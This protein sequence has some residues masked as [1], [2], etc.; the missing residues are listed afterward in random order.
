MS[1][2]LYA[3]ACKLIIFFIFGKQEDFI[4]FNASHSL[5]YKEQTVILLYPFIKKKKKRNTNYI[6]VSQYIPLFS[7]YY[8]C[9]KKFKYDDICKLCVN[10][11]CINTNLNHFVSQLFLNRGEDDI[12]SKHDDDEVDDDGTAT[13]DSDSKPADSTKD[14]EFDRP[15]SSGK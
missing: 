3:I 12:N 14:T 15:S 4:H 5:F 2:Y 6:L 13:K 1:I 11:Y 7:I 10:F 9:N 8:F